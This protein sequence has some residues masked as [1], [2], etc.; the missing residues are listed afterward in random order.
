[1]IHREGWGLLREIRHRI[2]TRSHHFTEQAVR[3]INGCIWIVHKSRLYQPP[4]LDV[5]VACCGFQRMNVIFFDALLEF[6]EFRFATGASGFAY[7]ALAFGAKPLTKP[8]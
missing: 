1:M 3:F 4:L 2:A 6:F 7:R 8:S 5:T